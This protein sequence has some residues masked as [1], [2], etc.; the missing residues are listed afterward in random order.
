MN[1]YTKEFRAGFKRS[2]VVAAAL[3]SAIVAIFSL[4]A[5]PAAKTPSSHTVGGGE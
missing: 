4:Y 1:M 2:F 3:L 5:H